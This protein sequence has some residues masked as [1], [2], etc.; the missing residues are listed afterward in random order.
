[1]L[2][3][4]PAQLNPRLSEVVIRPLGDDSFGLAHMMRNRAKIPAK[5]V[6]R[7]DGKPDF[8][9][10]WVSAGDPFPEQAELLPWAAAIQ[11]ERDDNLGKDHPHNHCLPGSPPVPIAS[12]PRIAK[13]V[14]TRTLLVILFED[15]PGFRQVFLD[16]RGHPANFDPSWMGHSVGRWDGDT[17]VID[18]VGFNDQSWIGGSFP[19]T[20]MMRMTER[21]RRADYGHMEVSAT[22]EDPGT[23]VKPLHMI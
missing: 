20:A 13:F 16:G 17:L 2:A 11:K 9:G 19:H 10:V 23:L 18:T 5:P 4:Q 12:V 7:I 22:F 14:Q 21:Y 6:P 15:V 3:A 1:M 8:S